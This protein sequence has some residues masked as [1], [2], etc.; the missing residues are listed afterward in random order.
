MVTTPTTRIAGSDAPA[1]VL[2]QEGGEEEAQ[3]VGDGARDQEQARWRPAAPTGSK[4]C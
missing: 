1:D 4:R 3:P 2:E